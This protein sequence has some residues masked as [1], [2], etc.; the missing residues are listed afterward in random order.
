MP[1]VGGVRR[2]CLDSR[3]T[4]LLVAAAYRSSS[5]SRTR[6]PASPTAR[7]PFRHHVAVTFPTRLSLRAVVTGMPLRREIA[8]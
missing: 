1:T 8:S 4:L 3:F 2:L 5:T 7:R 6:D